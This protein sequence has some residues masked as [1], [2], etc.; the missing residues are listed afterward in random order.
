MHF[1]ENR[2]FF[3]VQP[4]GIN[5]CHSALKSTVICSACGKNFWCEN[6][7]IKWQYDYF[8]YLLPV[9]QE[10]RIKETYIKI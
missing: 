9:Q 8:F 2:A 6:K 1:T 4:G 7:S 5:R 10:G 3:N